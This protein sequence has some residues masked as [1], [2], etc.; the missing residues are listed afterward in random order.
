MGGRCPKLC[1]LV[2]SPN[3]F[4]DVRPNAIHT[5][6]LWSLAEAMP[7]RR[8]PSGRAHLCPDA[9]SPTPMHAAKDVLTA[10][11]TSK[12]HELDKLKKRYQDLVEDNDAV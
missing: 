5:A 2:P 8:Y 10:R 1:A 9:P 7:H 6:A 12:T 3:A 11:L 4:E